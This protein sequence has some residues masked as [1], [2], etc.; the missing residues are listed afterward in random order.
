MAAGDMDGDKGQTAEAPQSPAPRPPPTPPSTLPPR[1]SSG[2]SGT[3]TALAPLHTLLASW[4]LH[5]SDTPTPDTPASDSPS[6]PFQPSGCRLRPPP[7]RHLTLSRPLCPHL[8]LLLLLQPWPGTLWSPPHPLPAQP[9]TLTLSLHFS[10]PDHPHTPSWQHVL[11][12][13]LAPDTL[14]GHFAPHTPT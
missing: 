5:A 1:R 12:P 3:F 14:H 11:E 7:R 8:L 2:S 6:P 13:S 10:T 4:P 9:C